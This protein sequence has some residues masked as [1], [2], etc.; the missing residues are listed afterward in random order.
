MGGCDGPG[1]V[2]AAPGGGMLCVHALPFVTV[3]CTASRICGDFLVA[4]RTAMML[5]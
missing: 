1:S 2:I 4:C 5:G 3:Y